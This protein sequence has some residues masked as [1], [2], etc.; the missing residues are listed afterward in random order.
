MY[1]IVLFL[2]NMEGWRGRGRPKIRWV[3]YVRQGMRE[4]AVSDEMTNDRGDWRE[5]TCCADPK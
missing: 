2:L 4:M 1:Y 5:R 3:D